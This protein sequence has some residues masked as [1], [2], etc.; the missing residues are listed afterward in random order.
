MLAVSAAG[1]G[2]EAVE[3][4][5]LARWSDFEDCAAPHV[6]AGGAGRVVV[7]SALESRPIKIPVEALNESLRKLTVGAV[8]TQKARE[9]L[10]RRTNRLRR[11][12]HAQ[13]GNCLTRAKLVHITPFFVALL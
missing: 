13:E 4:G 6:S 7:G 11:A 10:R 5:Q 9:R 8:E 12:E 2:A 1:L 3:R